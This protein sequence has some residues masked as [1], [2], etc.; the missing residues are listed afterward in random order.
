VI[1]IATVLYYD[2]FDY[3]QFIVALDEKPGIETPE[4]DYGKITTL[5]GLLTYLSD[6]KK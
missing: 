4:E 5:T 1:I 3:L 6:K 2:S